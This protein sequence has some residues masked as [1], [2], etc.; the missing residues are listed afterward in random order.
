MKLFSRSIQC[1]FN[2]PSIADQPL[3]K[4][5]WFQTIT[6]SPISNAQ[7]FTVVGDHH[8][9]ASVAILNAAQCPNAIIFAIIAVV[10][11]AL[12]SMFRTWP[13][14]HIAEKVFKFSPFFAHYYSTFTIVFIRLL[15]WIKTSPQH[16]G[17]HF[18]FRRHS[19]VT[20]MAMSPSMAL[21]TAAFDI[22]TKQ[23]I[24]AYNRCL[25][26]LTETIPIAT[27]TSSVNWRASS[28]LVK[29]LSGYVANMTASSKD[30]SFAH[31]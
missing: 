7:S 22:A 23:M 24:D 10:I 30:R 9:S 15:S 31:A 17:P 26:A 27:F 2:W 29:L 11:L 16:S 13:S 20:C 14:P 3:S 19:S 6:N 21:T 1:F 25:A 28:K 4:K 12:K 5:V 8:I 18:I